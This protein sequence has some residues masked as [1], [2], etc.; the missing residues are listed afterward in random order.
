[1]QVHELAKDLDV[2]SKVLTKA[3]GK[4][5]HMQSVTEEEI[6]KAKEMYG[7]RENKVE[8]KSDIVRLWTQI[9]SLTLK[10]EYGPIY[11]RDWKIGVPKGGKAHKA[12]CLHSGAGVME[13]VDKPFES[14]L[15]RTA[16][17]EFLANKAYTGRDD[18]PALRDGFGFLMA[19]F[20]GDKEVNEA[21]KLMEKG[22]MKAVI[23]YAVE[24]KSYKN[25]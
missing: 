25:I 19:L 7:D 1:M 5:S 13:I 17:G 8:T 4:T 16:F 21:S 10:T 15:D 12:I 22:N 14:T 6:A 9:K 18:E 23:Q 24:H 20:N 11:I 3:L 2:D